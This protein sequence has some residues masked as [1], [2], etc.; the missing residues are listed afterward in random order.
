LRKK[1]EERVEQ[2]IFRALYD[3]GRKGLGVNEITRAVNGQP[4]LVGSTLKEYADK[5]YFVESKDPNHSQKK[6]YHLN[7][8]PSIIDSMLESLTKDEQV[9]SN[10]FEIRKF[11][12]KK[13]TKRQKDYLIQYGV[14]RMTALTESITMLDL[15]ST[16]PEYGL[17]IRELSEKRMISKRKSRESLNIELRK[18]DPELSNMITY[19]MMQSAL[20]RDFYWFT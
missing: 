7:P 4:N 13:L 9:Q 12:G 1:V 5:G 16:S 17:R 18:I 15:L 20:N 8:K 3:K 10:Y 14:S 2:R 11:R 6:L 19:M